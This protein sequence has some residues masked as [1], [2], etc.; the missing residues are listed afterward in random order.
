M[1]QSNG[2]PVVFTDQGASAP[3]DVLLQPALTPAV[4]AAI[5]I[6]CTLCTLCTAWLCHP[7]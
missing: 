2:K 7:R 5:R 6:L 3:S 1:G 4:P